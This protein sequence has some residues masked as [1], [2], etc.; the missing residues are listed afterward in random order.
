MV[1]QLSVRVLPS[2]MVKAQGL[3]PS[4]IKKRE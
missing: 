1:I 2:I 4:I 3:I